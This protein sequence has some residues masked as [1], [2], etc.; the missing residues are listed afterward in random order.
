MIAG[1]SNKWAINDRNEIQYNVMK[2]NIEVLKPDFESVVSMF[3]C[4]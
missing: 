4:F 1:P 2:D 3:I